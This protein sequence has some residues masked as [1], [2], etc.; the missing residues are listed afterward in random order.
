MVSRKIIYQNGKFWKLIDF[1][2]QTIIALGKVL[3]QARYKINSQFDS[4]VSL[5]KIYFTSMFTFENS[6]DIIKA[7]KDEGKI[8]GFT[9]LTMQW[10]LAFFNI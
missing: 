2:N 4:K 3:C 7:V 10:L 6:A 8:K 1:Q 9:F 5:V